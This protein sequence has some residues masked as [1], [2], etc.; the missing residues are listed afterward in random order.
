MRK[1]GPNACESTAK[2]SA[3][4]RL[5]MKFY[6]RAYSRPRSERVFGCQAA[7]PVEAIGRYPPTRTSDASQAGTGPKVWKRPRLPQS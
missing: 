6:S 1:T 5:S 2:T 7:R 3:V 4:C